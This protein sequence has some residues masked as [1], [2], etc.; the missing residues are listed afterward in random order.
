[1]TMLA[2]VI[3][4]EIFEK[5]SSKKISKKKVIHEI[6]SIREPKPT[7]QPATKVSG[8]Y[9]RATTTEMPKIKSP[10]KQGKGTI[11][12]FSKFVYKSYTVPTF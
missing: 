3:K 8:I 6:N 1:M 7:M 9:T 10:I 4:A 12:F 2:I 11:L 5:P